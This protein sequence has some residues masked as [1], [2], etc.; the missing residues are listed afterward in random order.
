MTE[1]Q[2]TRAQQTL[3]A[4]ISLCEGIGWTGLVTDLLRVKQV[5]DWA[6]MQ[7]REGGQ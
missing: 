2:I 1:A 3:T 7:R 4:W 5:V 6:R